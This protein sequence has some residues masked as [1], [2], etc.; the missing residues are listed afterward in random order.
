MSWE[1]HI[2]SPGIHFTKV[3]WGIGVKS[4]TGV[5]RSR[6]TVQNK[7]NTC[8]FSKGEKIINGAQIVQSS[9]RKRWVIV[10]SSFLS[11]KTSMKQHKLFLKT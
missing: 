4:R 1:V 10:L 9:K 2:K 6:A 11:L 7:Y 5:C 8:A 3:N